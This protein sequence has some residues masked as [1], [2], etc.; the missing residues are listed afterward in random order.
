MKRF[1]QANPAFLE[2]ALA[3]ADSRTAGRARLLVD[4]DHYGLGLKD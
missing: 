1:L 3:S 4:E 2:T